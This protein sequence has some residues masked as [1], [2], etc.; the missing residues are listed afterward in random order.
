[1]SRKEDECKPLAAG[2]GD[3]DS[4]DLSDDSDDDSDSDDGRG[5]DSSTFQ[6][7]H[8][9]LVTPLP[10]PLSNILGENHGPNVSHKMCLRLA[11]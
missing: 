2:K 4:E 1:M 10:V 8:A 7:N 3:V 9:L 11:E 5:L 6:L